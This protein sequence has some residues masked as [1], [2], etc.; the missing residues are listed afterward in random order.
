MK[1]MVHDLSY[2][3]VLG[4][5]DQR[6]LISPGLKIGLYSLFAEIVEERNLSLI[7]I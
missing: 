1:S 2:H 5:E 4:T 7:H 6:P 3:I